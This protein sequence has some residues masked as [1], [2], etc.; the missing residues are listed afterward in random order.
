MIADP[1]NNHW[2]SVLKSLR[3]SDTCGANAEG[4]GG[5]QPGNT[6]AGG[7]QSRS[8]DTGNGPSGPHEFKN[9]KEADAALMKA[10][11]DF[12]KK[13]D[14]FAQMPIKGYAG[15][16]HSYA[17]NKGLR[18]GS[19]KGNNRAKEIADKLTDVLDKVSFPM[20]VKAFRA[21]NADTD[22]EGEAI[23]ANF[24]ANVG[25]AIVDKAFVSTTVSE[26]YARKWGE[27]SEAPGVLVEV[28]IPKGS[29]ALYIP[30]EVS[31]K[32]EYEVLVQRNSK[33][34]VQ[35]VEGSIV[36]LE[37][38]PSTLEDWQHFHT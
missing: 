27:G 35:S 29:K 36:K 13:L 24:K 23:L 21:I 17:V 10:H 34:K 19:F 9:D 5:F 7:S 8:L 22:E 20:T 25:K 18:E 14:Y 15:T 4:G 30:K 38:E 12:Y 33:F 11:A 3:K 6:C 26:K 31:G 32:Q 28:V 37:L 1:I 2:G 16:D